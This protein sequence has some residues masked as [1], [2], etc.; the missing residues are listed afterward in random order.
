MP[1]WKIIVLVVVAIVGSTSCELYNPEEQIP[2]YI[3]IDSFKVVDNLNA[4]EGSL[5]HDIRDAWVYVDD[6]PIG[7]YQLPAK[8][9]VLASNGTHKLTIGPG[10][11][12]SL[13]SGLRDNYLYYNAHIDKAFELTSGK[14]IQ[15]T[16]IT[17]YRDPNDLYTYVLSEDFENIYSEADTF[18]NSDVALTITRDS[19]LV[20]EGTGSGI[21]KLS[22][23]KQRVYVKTPSVE[24]PN[25]SKNVFFEFD[26]FTDY[27]VDVGLHINNDQTQDQ[28]ISILTLKPTTDGEG[29]KPWKKAYVGLDASIDLATNP[30]D[31]YIYFNVLEA[32]NSIGSGKFMLDNFKFCYSK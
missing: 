20:Y 15:L 14:T 10:I 1:D 16:P 2:A 11:Y 3:Q 25:G 19:S 27:F 31:Y 7:V 21:V 32:E 26:F 29:E 24:I 18:N 22:S 13:S 8:F 17:S 28:N 12:V 4:I 6:Q 9:P 30:F 5:S 23:D